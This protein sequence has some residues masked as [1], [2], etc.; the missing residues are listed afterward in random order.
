[1]PVGSFGLLDFQAQNQ[2]TVFVHPLRPRAASSRHFLPDGCRNPKPLLIIN[3]SV[4]AIRQFYFPAV[5]S[6]L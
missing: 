6:G 3:V 5:E 1:M 4:D 2:G